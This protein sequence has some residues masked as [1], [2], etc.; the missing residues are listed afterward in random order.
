M[1]VRGGSRLTPPPAASQTDDIA[2]LMNKASQYFDALETFW[3]DWVLSYD[4]EQQVGLAIKVDQARRGIHLDWL[5][6]WG[7]K[8]KAGG[9]WV[10]SGDGRFSAVLAFLLLVAIT[11]R[12]WVPRLA[13]WWH[14]K[15]QRN[16]FGK[17]KAKSRDATVV[18]V[19]MLDYLRR[20]G[21]E[22]PAWVTP[23]EFAGML[24]GTAYAA[25]VVELTALYYQVRYGA[26]Q[27]LGAKLFTLLD[28][29]E[30]S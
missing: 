5:R 24:Q 15:L 13:W 8:L 10:A 14:T 22:K 19:R 9:R 30:S 2:T 21:Y 23:N 3:Q 4:M 29:L 28:T 12:F 18:Y 25:P 17:G 1:K 27:A 11:G 16:R 6:D 26:D 7:D 20:K